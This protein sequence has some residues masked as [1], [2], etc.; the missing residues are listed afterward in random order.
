MSVVYSVYTDYSRKSR[1]EVISIY[2][3][4]QKRT[5]SLTI[6]KNISKMTSDPQH[7]DVLWEALFCFGRIIDFFQITVR[8]NV[9]FYW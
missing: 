4:A 5:H 7:D 9:V 6:N 1:G 8:K 2:E 3:I